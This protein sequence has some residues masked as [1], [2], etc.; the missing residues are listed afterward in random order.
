MKYG[1]VLLLLAFG[2]VSLSAGSEEAKRFFAEYQAQ[3]STAAKKE[4][5]DAALALDP[6][7]EYYRYE[8][9][10]LY[11]T[12]CYNRDWDIWIANA[13]EQHRRAKKFHADFPNYRTGD[14]NRKFVFEF[15][16]VFQMQPF[17]Y[18]YVRNNLPTAKQAKE[19]A[20]LCDEL[21]PLVRMDLK[22]AW[23]PY[24]LTD[25]ISSWKELENYTSVVYRTCL[26]ELYGSQ[27]R[28]WQERIEGYSE[29]LDAMEKFV[30]EHPEDREKTERIGAF[31]WF[32]KMA[33]SHGDLQT[34]D[35]VSMRYLSREIEPLLERMEQSTFPEIRA[36]GTRFRLYQALVQAPRNR[37]SALRVLEEFLTQH[38]D[39]DWLSDRYGSDM[40]SGLNTFSNWWIQTPGLAGRLEEYDR[41]RRARSFVEV[42]QDL[43]RKKDWAGLTARADEMRELRKLRIANVR[44]DD[45]Y[46]NILFLFSRSQ[47]LPGE[48]WR[49]FERMNADFDIKSRS[50]AELFGS[51]KPL[52]V[53]GLCRRENTI[54]LLLEQERKFFLG[55][56]DISLTRG[57]LYLLSP[58]PSTFDGLYS[59]G[60]GPGNLAPWDCNGSLAAIALKNG[61]LLLYDLK[62]KEE[63]IL[64]D[65]L[66]APARGIAIAGDKVYAL[67]GQNGESKQNYLISCN[68][69]GEDYRIHFS[70]VRIEK[71]NELERAF[72]EVDSLFALNDNELIFLLCTRKVNVLRYRI[73]ADRF[74]LVCEPGETASYNRMYRDNDVFYAQTNGHGSLIHRVDPEK[75]RADCILMQDQRYKGIQAP[76]CRRWPVQGPFARRNDLLFGAGWYSSV[77]DLSDP[78]KSPQLFLPRAGF[79]ISGRDGAVIYFCG[80]RYFEVAG[81]TGACLK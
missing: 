78:A 34:D 10:V 53:I 32:D 24:D 41:Q 52:Q 23:F 21:R 47:E 25:G 19:M 33:L 69:S 36:Q 11:S 48:A 12:F 22:R 28:F 54:F 64:P 68:L 70:N 7:N 65:V 9:L 42:V 29:I 5:L 27:E 61:D 55:V 2:S 60:F 13:R 8:E 49:F 67:C 62:E 80:F 57:T 58:E 59:R 71:K 79:L 75:N 44:V 38:P 74:E 1:L 77:V 31:F 51:T 50:L 73:D 66:P 63:H 39:G 26:M 18:I 30:Q 43:F 3:T 72:G 15:H 81:R 6:M 16:R 4:K 37:E 20:E 17:S 56:S 46:Y 40:R 35:E 76:F 45:P 14:W